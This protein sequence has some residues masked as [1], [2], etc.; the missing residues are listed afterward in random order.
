MEMTQCHSRGIRKNIM[1]G[2]SLDG[3]VEPLKPKCGYKNKQKR[4]S[5]L[6]M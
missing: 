1:D 5:C 2:L 4:F 3:I 6:I